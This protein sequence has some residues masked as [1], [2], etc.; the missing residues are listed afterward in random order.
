M[1]LKQA[2]SMWLDKR[3]RGIIKARFF[4]FKCIYKKENIYNKFLKRTRYFITVDVNQHCCTLWPVALLVWAKAA[5]SSAGC[6]ILFF[7]FN[8]FTEG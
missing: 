2:D 4:F 5:L 3:K 6:R 1:G 7:F 8:G